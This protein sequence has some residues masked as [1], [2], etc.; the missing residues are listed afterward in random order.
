MINLR[1][2]G[3]TGDR[4]GFLAI[5]FVK[6]PTQALTSSI[7]EV[8]K[9]T[10]RTLFHI[11]CEWSTIPTLLLLD[12]EAMPAHNFTKSERNRS[13]GW[14]LITIRMW[15]NAHLQFASIMLNLF[16]VIQVVTFF[17]QNTQNFGD[18][19]MPSTRH[20]TIIIFPQHNRI[21]VIYELINIS[22]RIVWCINSYSM[23]LVVSRKMPLEIDQT[24]DDPK[25]EIF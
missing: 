9:S 4:L 3:W 23:F 21:I 1:S 19:A 22:Y 7:T 8:S 11:G 20:C 6:S 25:M 17:S 12:Q 18:G 5:S 13:S 15:K 2:R 16:D 24:L 10:T 14:Q